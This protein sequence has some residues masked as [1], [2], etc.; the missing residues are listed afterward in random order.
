MY[1]NELQ[2]LINHCDRYFCDRKLINVDGHAA[3]AIEKKQNRKKT[4][5][6]NLFA[7]RASQSFTHI[8]VQIVHN[9]KPQYN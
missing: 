9:T 7:G 2:V 1:I 3:F 6:I 4:L 5:K 8:I